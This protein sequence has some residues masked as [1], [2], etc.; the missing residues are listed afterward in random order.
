MG[1]NQRMHGSWITNVISDNPK[2]KEGIEM[3]TPITPVILSG[4]SGSRLWPVSRKL[5]P[6]QFLPLIAEDRTLFQSTLE[7]LDGLADKQPAVIVCNEE[8]RFMVAEQLQEIGQANQGILLEPVGRNT[9]PA[10]AVAALS[11]LEK[12]GSDP[13]MLVLPA[14]HVIPDV[15]AFQQAIQQAS[16]LAEDGFLVTF[17]ITPISPETGY[18]YIEQ[19]SAITGFTN[20]WQVAA[21]AEKP[22]LETA[23]AYL[24]GGKH[25]W[26]SGIFMFK[27]SA[28]LRELE[29]YKPEILE[30]CKKTFKQAQHDLDFIRL[31]AATFK[32]CPSDSIDYAVMEHTR[33]AAIVPLNAGW[34]DVGAWSAVWEVSERD[35]ANN[36]LRGN[37]MTHDASNNLVFTEDRLVTLVGV[38][39]LIVIET[40]DATL[41]A[42]KSKAQDVKRIVTA[43]EAEGRSEA[44]IHRL[45]NRPWGCYDSVD[46]GE[47]FQ[48]KR[49]TVKPGAKLSLQKH[50]HRAEHWIV[51]KGTAEVTCDDKTFLLTENQS[52]YIPLGSVHRLANPGKV[53]L[54][55]VEVQSGSYLGEDDIVRLE[56]Q[57]GRNEA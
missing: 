6:K 56:D 47:R 35:A 5:R 22:N 2:M 50:H 23:T 24:C 25:L 55:L 52:T 45:V 18:G 34:N 16:A 9:A 43:L 46:A 48:V 29:T 15:A 20:A 36:V 51:V 21:F 30:A 54:E 3:A 7:R 10:V 53:P 57:Y 11:L 8:H 42:H 40:K 28:F 41:V 4:G 39:D 26:N 44:I 33:H 49:I 13:V 14:D 1:L 27:A 31:D 37:V 32:E 38:D 17:G 19:G 12:N